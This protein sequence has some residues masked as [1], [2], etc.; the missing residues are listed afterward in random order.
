MREISRLGSGE[1][2]TCGEDPP[3]QTI[4]AIAVDLASDIGQ[5]QRRRL[6]EARHVETKSSITDLVTDVDRESEQR[7]VERLGKA[8]SDDSILAEEGT[9]RQGT[10]GVRW[11]I[12]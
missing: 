11:V 9:L 12:D 3:L 5:L 10:S 2:T 4:L 6:F 7:I 1:N 8:R